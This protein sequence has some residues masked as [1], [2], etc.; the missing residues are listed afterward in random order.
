MIYPIGIACVAALNDRTL[1]LAG[2]LVVLAAVTLLLDPRR[3]DA[4]VFTGGAVLGPVA[5][6][7]AVEFGA[8][9]YATHDFLG[10]PLWLPVGWGLA[11][12]LIKRI[13]EGL[14]ELKGRR[15]R[16]G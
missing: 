5:E 16:S 4:W 9:T 10:I 1:A 6:I 12:L 15:S 11:T 8:W 13:S 7:I 14:L 2:I 3:G